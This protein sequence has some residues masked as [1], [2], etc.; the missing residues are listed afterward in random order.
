MGAFSSLVL[1]K[2]VVGERASPES[3]SYFLFFAVQKAPPAT[4]SKTPSHMFSGQRDAAGITLRGILV[5]SMH[6][7]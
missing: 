1:S 5:C 3:N 4:L 7:A 6:V 2:A